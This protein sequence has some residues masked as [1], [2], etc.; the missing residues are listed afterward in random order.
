MTFLNDL[1]NSEFWRRARVA[2]E[3]PEFELTTLNRYVVQDIPPSQEAPGNLV[4][5]LESPHRLEVCRQHPLA[6]ESGLHVTDTLA[7]VLQLPH[8]DPHCP[9]GAVLTPEARTRTRSLEGMG[10]MNASQLPMQSDPYPPPFRESFRPLLERFTTI[11]D[12]PG[13]RTRQDDLTAEVE[14]LL[15]RDLR[16]RVLDTTSRTCFALCGSVA[17]HLYHKAVKGTGSQRPTINVPHPSLGQWKQSEH[18]DRLEFLKCSIRN[19][20]ISGE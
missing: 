2:P 9:F 1:G 13:A 16:N 3:Q 15:L 5:L 4:L 18:E 8:S 7:D 6:G 17:W 19:L 14:R 10:I 12:G 20:L 11:R